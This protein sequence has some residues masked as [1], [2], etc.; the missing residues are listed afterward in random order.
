[1]LGKPFFQLVVLALVGLAAARPAEPEKI[2]LQARITGSLSSY[3]A[4][5]SPIAL[6]GVL[7]NIGPDG[8]KVPGAGSGLVIASPSTSNPDCQCCR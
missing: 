3:I 1:M 4:T 8:A 5:E 6:Q 2:Q 7:D